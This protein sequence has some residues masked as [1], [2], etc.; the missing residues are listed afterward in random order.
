MSS[1][2]QARVQVAVSNADK[3]HAFLTAGVIVATA[4]VLVL[5]GI[6]LAGFGQESSVD[7]MKPSGVT[8]DISD[9]NSDELATLLDFDVPGLGELPE[10]TQPQIQQVLLAVTESASTVV[11]AREALVGMQEEAGK[12]GGEGGEEIRIPG[13]PEDNV[14]PEWERWKIQFSPESKEEYLKML[15]AL[16]ISMG[17]VDQ[18]SNRIYFLTKMSSDEPEL[19]EGDRKDELARRLYFRNT[20]DELKDWDIQQFVD[21]DVDTEGHI[22]VQFYPGELQE[23]L[24]ET[25]KAAIHEVKVL[26]EVKQTTFACEKTEDG[27]KFKVIDIKYRPDPG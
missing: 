25:E 20:K 4:L 6:W 23:L 16:D 13:P 8:I 10:A 26:R 15:D 18:T 2:K 12:E 21:A 14:L 19:S 17:A 5:Y 7:R 22:V 27:Y 1:T 3:Y 11:G 9:W 24:L